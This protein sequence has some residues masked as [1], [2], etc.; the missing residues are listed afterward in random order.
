MARGK[1][2]TEVDY[3]VNRQYGGADGV[4]TGSSSK[5]FTLL[6][7]LKQGVPFASS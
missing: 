2:Q 5:L 3:A 4:Q 7:A 6:T 1:G